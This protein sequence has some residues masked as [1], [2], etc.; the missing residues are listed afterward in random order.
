MEGNVGRGR[1]GIVVECVSAG[2]V[3]DN[4]NN[5]ELSQRE[6]RI[7]RL[8]CPK[9]EGEKIQAGH[10]LESLKIYLVE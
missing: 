9:M 4:F 7:K 1:Y 6:V 10:T 5:T 3:G 8:H 2:A